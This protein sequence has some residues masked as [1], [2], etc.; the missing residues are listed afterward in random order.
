MTAYLTQSPSG[1]YSYRRR[2][3]DDYREVLGKLEKKVSL[4][5]KDYYVAVKR[6]KK[7]NDEFEK[8]IVKGH[9]KM[10]KKVKH[11]YVTK[12]FKYRAVIQTNFMTGVHRVFFY[13][14]INGVRKV[15]EKTKPTGAYKVTGY[16]SLGVPALTLKGATPVYM[17]EQIE[18]NGQNCELT[19]FNDNDE[20]VA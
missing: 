10:T 19:L 16:Q 13:M 15:V 7:V 8:E 11:K 18:W 3:P 14:Y 20:E 12:P 4:K 9:L 17:D 1:F 6:L 2:I 5:T